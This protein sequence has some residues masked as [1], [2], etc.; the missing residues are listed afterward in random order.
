[1]GGGKRENKVGPKM[2]K[3]NKFIKQANFKTVYI[4]R[5]KY[6]KQNM[7]KEKWKA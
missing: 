7:I 4:N 3:L 5:F 2:Q 1:M 6:L